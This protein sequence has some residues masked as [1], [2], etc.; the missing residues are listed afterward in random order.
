MCHELADGRRQPLRELLLG[1][2][3]RARAQHLGGGEEGVGQVLLV[4][5]GGRK[6]VG[7]GQVDE[8]GGLD[9]QVFEEE[10]V[11]DV[12]SGLGFGRGQHFEVRKE[13]DVLG[14]VIDGQRLGRGAEIGQTSPGRF[15][16]PLLRVVVP[17]FMYLKKKKT[18]AH[19]KKFKIKNKEITFFINVVCKG[20]GGYPL[21]TI[22]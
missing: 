9:D 2:E 21:K 6:D 3:R 5:E 16:D 22:A 13:F 8:G 10:L 12:A 4:L 18:N 1:R 15:L 7:G 17:N 20:L 11:A 14:G 19:T